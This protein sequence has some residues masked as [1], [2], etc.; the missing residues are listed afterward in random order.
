MIK[1][2]IYIHLAVVAAC[3]LAGAVFGIADCLRTRKGKSFNTEAK[4][5]TFC[6]KADDGL[7]Y[8]IWRIKEMY[9]LLVLVVSTMLSGAVGFILGILAVSG[10]RKD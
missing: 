5:M 10:S 1:R 8:Y 3:L 4:V 9:S 7:D 6:T 2:V